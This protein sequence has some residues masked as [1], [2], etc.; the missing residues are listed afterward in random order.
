MLF[1]STFRREIIDYPDFLQT[2]KVLSISVN[3]YTNITDMPNQATGILR[4]YY[5]GTIIDEYDI[6]IFYNATDEP[7]YW[8]AD[9]GFSETGDDFEPKV[10]L[11]LHKDGWGFNKI[12]AFHD[13]PMRIWKSF[14]SSIFNEVYRKIWTNQ[15]LL[16]YITDNKGPVW[17]PDRINYGY[18]FGKNKGLIKKLI[19]YLDAGHD[20]GTKLDF[21]EYIGK[22]KSKVVDGK[23]QYAHS[24]SDKFFL[25]SQ[26]RGQFSGF[27]ASAR[28][29][30]IIQYW[31]DGSK[32]IIQPGP[33]FE[34][35]KEGKL[36]AL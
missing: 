7:N 21:L 29:A 11:G 14:T 5:G 8:S 17:R 6:M 35:F 4:I 33:N 34:A 13:D 19:D 20:N 3:G 10:D 12:Y 30:G 22:L 32:F 28:N 25:P 15:D 31:K 18:T 9:V 26:W 2:K 36:K 16:K 1:R 23:K 27:F 24:Y